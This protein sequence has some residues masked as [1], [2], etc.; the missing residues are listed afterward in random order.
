MK[1]FIANHLSYLA[2]LSSVPCN[3]FVIGDDIEFITK[4]TFYGKPKM[5]GL[6]LS[7]SLLGARS[8][9]AETT[10]NTKNPTY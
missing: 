1:I 9:Q 3:F 2:H 8:M 10:K 7:L 6:F 4:V 5:H